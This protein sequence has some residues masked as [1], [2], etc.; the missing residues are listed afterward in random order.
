D[1]KWHFLTL[2]FDPEFDTPATLQKYAARNHYDPAYWNFLTGALIDIDALTEQFGLYF[3]R[4]G[5]SGLNFNHNLRTVVINP[6]GKVQKVFAGNE[7]RV[8]ELVEEIKIAANSIN[9]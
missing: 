2:S 6:A 3:S 8:D 5:P 4:E 1:G 7:W 9:R